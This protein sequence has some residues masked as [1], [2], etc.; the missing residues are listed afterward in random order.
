M[1]QTIHNVHLSICGDGA[2]EVALGEVERFLST[3]TVK[4]SQNEKNTNADKGGPDAF[5][6]SDPM[7]NSSPD[8]TPIKSRSRGD[9]NPADIKVKAPPMNQSIEEW[10]GKSVR[11]FQLAKTSE[12]IAEVDRQLQELLKKYK[13]AGG[14]DEKCIGSVATTSTIDCET[15][16]GENSMSDSQEPN[17]AMEYIEEVDFGFETSTTPLSI[18]KVPREKYAQASGRKSGI[19]PPK[20]D[21]QAL[22]LGSNLAT[23][24]KRSESENCHLADERKEASKYS[25]LYK[26][27]RICYQPPKRKNTQQT[28]FNQ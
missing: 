3:E 27:S 19:V 13:T 23:T 12:A 7:H 21:L 8:E 4:F 24:S 18:S 15:L 11:Q 1:M 14:A 25:L 9:S 28:P 6:N 22:G 16:S 17:F 26:T 2:I 5:K 20:V 10:R